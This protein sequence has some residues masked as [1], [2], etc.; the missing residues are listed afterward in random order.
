[1]SRPDHTPDDPR[2]FVFGSNRRGMHGAGAAR[3]ARIELG[4]RWGIG[5]G[6]TGRAYAL[7][8]CSSPGVALP[9]AA[10]AEA[11]ER[12]KNLA[13]SMPGTR[14]YVS[15]VGCGFAGFV[16]ADIAPLFA[17]APDNC[18]LSDGWRAFTIDKQQ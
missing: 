7:P 17:D 12:F 16:A 2:V 6:M 9:Y 11:V 1:M 5:E 10:V 13:R 14:F 3:Y 18:D 8:T 4:A 15:E